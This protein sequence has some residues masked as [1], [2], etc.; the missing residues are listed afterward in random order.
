MR[1]VLRKKGIPRD[2]VTFRTTMKPAPP[3]CNSVKSKWKEGPIEC[4]CKEWPQ[5]IDNHRG[6]KHCSPVEEA[7]KD[8]DN[9]EQWAHHGQPVMYWTHGKQN[10]KLWYNAQVQELRKVIFPSGRSMVVVGV[11]GHFV[12]PRLDIRF[13]ICDSSKK[14]NL[15]E[16]QIHNEIR[17]RQDPNSGPFPANF[18]Y[19][20]QAEQE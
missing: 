11:Q 20:T 15:T 6:A 17:S 19:P 13:T 16:M 2:Q 14:L 8:S 5:W 3:L 18:R 1:S 7:F 9:K 12:N 10:T 4:R